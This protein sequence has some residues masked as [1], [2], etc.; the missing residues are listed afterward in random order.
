MVNRT[1][2]VLAVTC[3]GG[4]GRTEDHTNEGFK[5]EDGPLVSGMGQGR[6]FHAEDEPM[7]KP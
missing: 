2:T 5:G 1:D 4:R 3:R 7:S 6:V